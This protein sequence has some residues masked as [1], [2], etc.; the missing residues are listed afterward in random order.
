MS[1]IPSFA[2]IV[3]DVYEIYHSKKSY[4]STSKISP[5]L[6]KKYNLQEIHYKDPYL[7]NPKTKEQ[8]G[9]L[10]YSLTYL[11]LNILK[12]SGLTEKKLMM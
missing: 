11:S 2:T 4:K 1:N 9:E 6:L 7:D 8:S 12:S 10:I 3:A 5:I